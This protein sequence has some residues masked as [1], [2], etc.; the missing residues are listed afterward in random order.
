MSPAARIS[1][2]VVLVEIP[3]LD[4]TFSAALAS[5][6]IDP[7]R[8]VNPSTAL[9]TDSVLTPAILATY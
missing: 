8:L 7:K 6:D 3:S 5:S 2:P 4:K 1:P 9:V